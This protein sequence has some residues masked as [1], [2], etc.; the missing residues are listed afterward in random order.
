MKPALLVAALF[1]ALLFFYFM[2]YLFSG[3]LLAPRAHNLIIAFAFSILVFS[4]WVYGLRL[5]NL[6]SGIADFSRL[7]LFPIL[8]ILVMISSPFTHEIIYNAFTGVMY[9]KVMHGRYL[10]I[11]D[12][13]QN[14]RHSVVL[15]PYSEDF[16][17]QGK[18][19][20]PSFLQGVLKKKIMNY[21]DW[22]H[23][24]DPVQDTALYIH[25]YAEYHHI[26]TI[27]FQGKHY[28]RIGL[29]QYENGR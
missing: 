4:G 18:K 17:K 8:L 5:K 19:T 24:Q 23:F 14:G 12:A 28:E 21:P 6:S 20:L 29:M 16:A 10:A 1:F 3:E 2:I 27:W 9:D 15:Y 25:Y 13:K 22:M 26:D 7:P 11:E